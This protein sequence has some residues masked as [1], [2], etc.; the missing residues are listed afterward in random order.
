MTEP[1]LSFRIV[2]WIGIIDQLASTEANR[3]LK[4]HG[5][6]L[7][8]FVL[9]NHFSHRPDE[10]RTITAIARAFQQP[11][12]G[13]TKTVQKLVAKGWLRETA[14][15]KDGRS[16]LL[17]ITPRGLARHQAA[18]ATLAPNLA[19]AFAGWTESEQQELFA[20]LDRLKRWFDDDR[21]RNRDGAARDGAPGPRARRRA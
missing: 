4:A 1:P 3:A 7:P 12:P 20:R 10:P 5:L 17:H 6:A 11:Q 14:N 2:N 19:R 16:K 9:L 21:G 15:G 8:Q 18:L 13:L